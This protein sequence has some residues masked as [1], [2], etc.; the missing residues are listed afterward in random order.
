[1]RIALVIPT[2]EAGGA[3]K[4][5]S[6]MANHFARTGWTVHLVTWDDGRKAP[7]FPLDARVC[8]TAVDVLRPA[9]NTVGALRGNLVRIARM[10]QVIREIT[11]SVVI[12][13]LNQT[14]IISILATVG[15]GIPVVVAER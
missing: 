8:R 10:R 1:M 4:V 5:M 3:E 12:S 11:P 15:M 14:N 2:L 13:F 6:T 7:F 9:R